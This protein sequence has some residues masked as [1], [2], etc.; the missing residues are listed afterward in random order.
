MSA[1][2][3]SAAVVAQMKVAAEIIERHVALNMRPYRAKDTDGDHITPG[4]D[5]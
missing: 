1:Q 2:D 3:E 4:D 5:Q